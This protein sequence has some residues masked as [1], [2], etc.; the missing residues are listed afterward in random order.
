MEKKIDTHL[1]LCIAST[2]YDVHAH[3]D[4]AIAASCV[5]IYQIRHDAVSDCAHDL[6]FASPDCELT[7][8]AKGTTYDRSVTDLWRV[9]L[10]HNCCIDECDSRICQTN[11]RTA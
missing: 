10:K 1:D 4:E 8:Y 2:Q 3:F 9:Y 6:L 5:S 11:S 7:A